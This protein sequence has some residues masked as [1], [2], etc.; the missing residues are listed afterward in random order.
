MGVDHK[1]SLIE[2]FLTDFCSFFSKT[3]KMQVWRFHLISGY[4]SDYQREFHTLPG[5]PQQ[6]LANTWYIFKS[7]VKSFFQIQ[8]TI[9]LSKDIEDCKF[10][11][12]LN[13]PNS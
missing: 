12:Y 13:S 7:F 8:D 6:I 3:G 4:C 5:N 10:D 9:R 1:L 2:V 11:C